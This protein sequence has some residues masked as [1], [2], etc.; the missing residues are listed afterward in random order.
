MPDQEWEE[1]QRIQD[2]ERKNANLASTVE[3]YPPELGDRPAVANAVKEKD[4][5]NKAK[6]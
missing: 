2:L 6:K 1:Q 4:E 5:K 3:V